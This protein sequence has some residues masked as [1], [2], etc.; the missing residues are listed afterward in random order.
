MSGATA[1]DKGMTAV[2]DA[3]VP[4]A[5]IADPQ[6]LTLVGLD[7]RTAAIVMAI[8][9]DHTGFPPEQLYFRSIRALDESPSEPL[10]RSTPA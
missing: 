4:E 2:A 5:P 8:V 3:P 9:C 6:G 7:E 10:G 1:K